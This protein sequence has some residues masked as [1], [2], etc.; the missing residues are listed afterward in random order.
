MTRRI[1]IP[2]ELVEQIRK[3][4]CV[5]FLGWDNQGAEAGSPDF[6]FD[7]VELARQIASR[8]GLAS[9]NMPVYE[10]ATHFAIE[11][12]PHALVQFVVDTVES[13]CVEPPAFYELLVQLPFNIIV[14]TCMHN[15]LE[16]AL[17]ARRKRFFTIVRDEEI[18]FIDD[19]RLLIVKLYGDVD[20]KSN[21]VLT[22]DDYIALLEDLPNISD[23]LKFYFSTKTL[24]FIGYNLS[25][26]H[27]LQLYSYAN[28]RTKGYQRRAFAVDPRPTPFERRLWERRN[29]YLVEA[30]PTEF[31]VELSRQIDL[32]ELPPKDSITTALIVGSNEDHRSPY[33]FLNSYDESDADIF[34]G[35]EADI[36]NTVRKLL[37][38]KLM[39]VYGRSGYGKTSLLNAGVTPVLMANGYVPVYVRCAGDPVQMIKANTL[40]RVNQLNDRSVQELKDLQSRI[41]TISLLEFLKEVRITEQRPIVVLIDQFEEF[42]ISLGYATREHFLRELVECVRHPYLDTIFVI[43]MREDF[44]AE[45]Y[46]IPEIGSLINAHYRLRALAL[47]SARKAIVEPALRFK[48]TYEEGLVETILDELADRQQIDPAQLQ[49]V[50]DRLYNSL[51]QGSS[52]ITVSLYDS[53]GGV[54]GILAEYVDSILDTFGARRKEMA[55]K[56]LYSMVTSLFTRVPLT[57]SDALS[58]ADSTASWDENHVRLLLTD[59]VRARLIRRTDEFEEEAYEL[60]HEY[61]INRIREWID[62]AQLRVKEAQDLLRQEHNNWRRHSIPI[63]KVAFEVIDAQRESII[64]T[65]LTKAYLLAMAIRHDLELHYWL[66]QNI[67]NNLAIDYALELLREGSRD[68]KRLASI[69]LGYLSRD[70]LLLDEVYTTLSQVGNPN[71]IKR[72]DELHAEGSAFAPTF[73][74]R[75]Q[76][77]IVDRFTSKMV[78]VDGGPFTMGTSEAIIKE[79]AESNS[80]P[81]T[82]F[83][84]QYPE[85]SEIV[86]AFYV[87]KYPVTNSEFREFK[88]THTFPE[89]HDEH[90]ATNVS[91]YEAAEY[92]DWLG[93]RLLSEEEWEKAARGVDGRHF[94][95]GNDWIPE[96]CNTRLSGYGGTTPVRH[97]ASGVSPYQCFDMSGNVWEWTSTWLNE[98][99]KQKVLKGGSWSKYGILPWT[100]YRF[101]YETDSGYSNVGFRCGKSAVAHSDLVEEEV[102][103]ATEPDSF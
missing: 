76:A 56:L 103:R 81:L 99:K 2:Y 44:L 10:A 30:T 55:K 85:H 15:L 88:I 72:I 73:S 19:E 60:T 84:G 43:S 40:D 91:W 26:P 67:S 86:E 48:V 89:G 78:L 71:T 23:L 58:I 101:N 63:S 14:S 68:Q 96:N 66:Q 100:W 49:I 65:N 16:G 57:I 20:H 3:G 28:Q 92:A 1:E 21:L 97:F 18:S 39:I 61:L 62:L 80:V 12:S 45:L 59:L 53:L 24:L 7:E 33:K 98:E 13:H 94:P 70:D 52:Q 36:K 22:R 8:V 11:E 82:F 50:C 64:L 5:L 42:F 41:A 6:F 54:S 102:L 93:K 17:H 87:D 35:R 34:F 46:E 9:T 27:F 47:D 25:N 77:A 95:W 74:E 90:P 79:I 29:L 37:Y 4:N 31:L 75:V 83:D 32:D 38:S 51:P 69:V